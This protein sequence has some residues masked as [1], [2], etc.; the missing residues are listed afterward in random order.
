[1]MWQDKYSFE[2][3]WKKND[4]IGHVHQT[5]ANLASCKLGKWIRPENLGSIHPALH[6]GLKGGCTRFEIEHISCNLLL[7]VG[8]T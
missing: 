2:N 7:Y 4:W 8:K 1:M 5:Y 6:S 3:W